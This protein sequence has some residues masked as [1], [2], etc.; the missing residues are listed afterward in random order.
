MGQRLD[1]TTRPTPHLHH[2]NLYKNQ[3]QLAVSMTIAKL[4]RGQQTENVSQTQQKWC[5]SRCLSQ[6]CF[7][8]PLWRCLSKMLLWN[9]LLSFLIFIHLPVSTSFLPLL[10]FVIFMYWIRWCT[11]IV[12]SGCLATTQSPRWFSAVLDAVVFSPLN[13]PLNYNLIIGS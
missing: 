1:W 13:S 4:T 5:L 8:K 9:F 3:Q 2:C 12:L 6:C 7:F 10:M 11:R